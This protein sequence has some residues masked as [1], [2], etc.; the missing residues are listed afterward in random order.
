MKIVNN[1]VEEE[2]AVKTGDILVGDFNGDYYIVLD[3]TLQVL[4]L[5]TLVV[6]ERKRLNL[7]PTSIHKEN[8]T[9]VFSQK[10]EW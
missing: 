2:K 10:E 9:I 5:K 3:N 7:L 1:V 8:I 4:K 6:Y